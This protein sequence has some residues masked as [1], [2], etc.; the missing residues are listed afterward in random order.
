MRKCHQLL[1]GNPRRYKGKTAAPVIMGTTGAVIG[2]M[3][4]GSTGAAVG[5]MLGAMLGQML[6]PVDSDV[7]MPSAASYAVQHSDKGTPIQKVYGTRKVAGNI[8][9]MDDLITMLNC[10]AC[11]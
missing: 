1:I 9:W 11:C 6:F 2:S 8:I 5:Y 4:G 10:I 7:Q 3:V